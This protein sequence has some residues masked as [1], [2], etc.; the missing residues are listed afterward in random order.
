VTTTVRSDR[1]KYRAT[2]FL[3]IELMVILSLA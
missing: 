1:P 2:T 3:F